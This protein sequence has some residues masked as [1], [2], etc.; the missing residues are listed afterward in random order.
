[1]IKKTKV[2]RRGSELLDEALARHINIQ[3]A[4]SVL[5]DIRYICH[6]KDVES[7]LKSDEA[8]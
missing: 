4:D 3:I 8:A 7:D 5:R 2:S 1:M 6:K